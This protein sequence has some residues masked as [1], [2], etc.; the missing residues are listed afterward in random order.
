[1]KLNRIILSIL[2]IFPSLMMTGCFDFVKTDTVTEE[3]I[4]RIREELPYSTEDEKEEYYYAMLQSLFDNVT[5][6]QKTA[7]STT[8][9]ENTSDIHTSVNAE[10]Q[11]SAL[12]EDV[13]NENAKQSEE[14]YV[15]N[16]NTKKFH[17]IT[18]SSSA[19]IKEK[20]YGESGDRNW[21]ISN[22][23]QPC[24]LCKP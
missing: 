11:Y 2:I 19:Q 7:Y 14:V 24:K 3:E 1:M 8:N 18:C 5:P 12:P 21:L 6:E 15:F 9:G 17:K 10:V 20:N 13:E 16:K 4:L 22:G 23:Y